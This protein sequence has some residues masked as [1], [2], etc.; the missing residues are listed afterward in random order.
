L[1][2]WNYQKQEH[3]R[4][5]E[6]QKNPDE[7]IIHTGKL[8]PSG[9]FKPISAV[10]PHKVLDILPPLE[11][12][13]GYLKR[14]IERYN[15]R[16][17]REAQRFQCQEHERCLKD[18]KNPEEQVIHT[19]KLI[20]SGQFK[21]IHTSISHKTLIIPPVTVPTASFVKRL[22][23]RYKLRRFIETQRSRIRAQQ[24]FL[25]DEHQRCLD[26]QKDPTAQVIH[27]GKLIPSGQFK[28][29]ESEIIYTHFFRPSDP[30]RD[31]KRAYGRVMSQFKLKCFIQ[32]RRQEI[33]MI[34]QV[35]E[36]QEAYAEV[37]KELKF[38]QI[39][40]D[41][42]HNL[43]IWNEMIHPVQGSRAHQCVPFDNFNLY[44]P[45]TPT[46]GSTSTSVST[47]TVK[48][49]TKREKIH[50]R[51][52]QRFRSPR[53]FISNKNLNKNILN[54]DRKWNQHY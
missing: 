45:S 20:P 3:K 42:Q 41:L 7:Q 46:P 9:Q 50:K 37:L 4:C 54:W 14:L 51:H 47:K 36:A 12:E 26:A 25:K 34:S 30:P 21:P 11:T 2:N 53:Q 52:H 15:F 48:C 31:W 32:E 19:G 17:F 43:S 16:L 5:L 23:E 10:I 28:P 13:E 35:L 1:Q 44:S 22:V 24:Q 49:V 40:L 29:V 18:R 8:I 33:F 6:A 38:R 39:D 27:T